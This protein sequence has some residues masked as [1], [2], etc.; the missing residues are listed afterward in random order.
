MVFIDH[1]VLKNVPEALVTGDSGSNKAK[2]QSAAPASCRLL[3]DK[4]VQKDTP[5]AEREAI[6]SCFPKSVFIY[7]M[8]IS[9]TFIPYG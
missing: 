2:G 1:S 8:A 7:T 4:K 6:A 9:P 5:Y 3:Y